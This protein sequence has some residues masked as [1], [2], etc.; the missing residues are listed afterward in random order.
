[1][2]R[3]TTM[4]SVIHGMDTQLLVEGVQSEKDFL[5]A[6]VLRA[7]LVKGAYY[8]QQAQSQRQVAAG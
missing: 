6:K 2:R 7:D 4:L 1:M 8:E 5:L 3:K